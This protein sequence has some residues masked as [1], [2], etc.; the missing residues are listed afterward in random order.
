[1]KENK[2]YASALAASSLEEKKAVKAKAKAKIS[3]GGKNIT[4]KIDN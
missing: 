1:M 3:I 4:K 2:K